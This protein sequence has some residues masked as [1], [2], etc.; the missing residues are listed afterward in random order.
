M[1]LIKDY[2]EYKL[3]MG[4]FHAERTKNPKL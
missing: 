4:V 1:D 3:T 2:N